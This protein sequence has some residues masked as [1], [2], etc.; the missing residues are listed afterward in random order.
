VQKELYLTEHPL[1]TV[2]PQ[3]L[4]PI[5]VPSMTRLVTTIRLIWT[6]YKNFILLSL[7]V[8]GFCLRFFWLNGFSSFFGI[9]WGKAVTL[10]LTYYIV[11]LNRKEEYYYYQNLGIGKT[12]LWAVTL[13]FDFILFLFLII[14]LSHFR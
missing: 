9:F 8:T 4:K 5:A 3:L 11:N 6:F 10:A 7:L 1:P 12:L 2:I 14:Q 13:S